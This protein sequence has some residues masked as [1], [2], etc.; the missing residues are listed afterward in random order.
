MASFR[1]HVGNLPS[2]GGD[3][4]SLQEQDSDILLSDHSRFVR[5][6]HEV[7]LTQLRSKML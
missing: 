3:R 4:L 1:E 2:Q 7:L 5:P 6:R